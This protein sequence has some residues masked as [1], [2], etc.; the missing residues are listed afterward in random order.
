M[1]NDKRVIRSACRMCHGVC[2]VLVHMEGERVVK[3]AGDP[4][5]PISRGY[6]CPKGAASAE[7]LYHPDRLTHPLRR[8]GKRGENK[9][10]RISWEE[11]LD[12]IARR[13]A[14]IKAESGSEYVASGRGPAGR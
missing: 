7:L 4:D 13:F 12:E 8:A 5:S 3:I 11:A 10:K 14:A 2:Q 6:L 9:W 1:A